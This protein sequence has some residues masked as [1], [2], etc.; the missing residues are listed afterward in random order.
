VEAAIHFKDLERWVKLNAVNAK[1]YD[2]GMVVLRYA[3]GS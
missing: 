3:K 2:C 1:S